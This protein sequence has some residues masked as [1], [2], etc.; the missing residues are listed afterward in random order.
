[1]L[2]NQNT[3]RLDDEFI[4]R[5]KEGLPIEKAAVEFLK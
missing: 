4:S 5:Y 2:K 3:R 1:M